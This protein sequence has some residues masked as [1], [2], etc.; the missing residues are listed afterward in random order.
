MPIKRNLKAVLQTFREKIK[1]SINVESNFAF[2]SAAVI[3][4]EAYFLYKEHTIKLKLN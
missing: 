1:I 4:K 2:P 3:R